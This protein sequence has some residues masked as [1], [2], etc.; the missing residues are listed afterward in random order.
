MS[1]TLMSVVAAF[2][3]AMCIGA[4]VSA[5]DYCCPSQNFVNDVQA[6]FSVSDPLPGAI[7]PAPAEKVKE[8][9]ETYVTLADLDLST[10]KNVLRY[11]APIPSGLPSNDNMG[12]A[13]PVVVSAPKVVYVESA[14]V[15]ATSYV[16]SAPTVSYPTVGLTST[17]S[18]SNCA[19]CR[20]NR[21]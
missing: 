20:R 16:V 8:E 12:V 9:R 6:Y 2:A 5:S 7:P 4:T 21:R 18:N 13:T 10:I 3:L 17:S 15:A 11:T 14:P 19:S 1:R